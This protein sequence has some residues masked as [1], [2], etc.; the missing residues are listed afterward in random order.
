MKKSL[1][2]LFTAGLLSAALAPA[3]FAQLSSYSQ[4]FEA[5]DR[6]SGSALADDGWKLFVNVYQS[7]GVNTIYNYGVFT[8]PNNIAAPNISVISDST[9]APVGNQGLVVF[10]DYNNGDHGLN[11]DRRIEVNVFQ[12]QIISAADIGQVYEFSFIAAPDANLINLNT[13]ATAFIKTLNPLAGFATTNFVTV[14]TSLLAAGNTALS[15]QL[16]LSDPALE[17][18]I[19]Q[20]GFNN[21]AG[22]FEASGVNYDNISFDIVPE[23]ASLALIGLGGLMMATRRRTAR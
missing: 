3:G 8:A 19:L 12:E 7:N 2:T 23:P 15:V 9:A 1:T 6:T 13:L 4:D 22:N 14:D 11:P 5:L 10:N 20:F 17:G 18:Q 21:T 16:D